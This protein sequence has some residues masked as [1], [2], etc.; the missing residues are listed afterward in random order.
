M[1]VTHEFKRG[2]L[3]NQLPKRR[4]LVAIRSNSS[5]TRFL[6]RSPHLD[7][8]RFIRMR[9]R[10]GPKEHFNFWRHGDKLTQTLDRVAILAGHREQ[11]PGL[12]AS[13]KFAVE[14]GR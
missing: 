14:P 12:D 7:L 9:P 6:N 3:D 10:V 13:S 11:C 1:T 8:S 5:S 2:F 4:R